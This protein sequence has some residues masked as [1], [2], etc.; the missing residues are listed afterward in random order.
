MFRADHG[1]HSGA[2]SRLLWLT[3]FE[4]MVFDVMAFEVI[5]WMP[6]CR[7]ASNSSLV[8]MPLSL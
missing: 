3:S 7:A 8:P 1:E 4:V 6:P 5:A 2:K